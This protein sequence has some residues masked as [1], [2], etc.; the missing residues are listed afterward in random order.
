MKPSKRWTILII[1]CLT[2]SLLHALWNTVGAYSSILLT[3][4]GVF[5]YA[6]L[7]AAILKARAL[8][9][10]RADNFATRIAK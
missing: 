7:A 9:P 6:F 2:A 1:G 5:S 8:S 4:V 10:N 3:V